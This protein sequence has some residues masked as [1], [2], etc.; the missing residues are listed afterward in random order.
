M[1]GLHLTLWG[2]AGILYTS[3]LPGHSPQQIPVRKPR[4]Q[5]AFTM[6]DL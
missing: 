4:V 2:Y 6:E 3:L 1:G 5:L